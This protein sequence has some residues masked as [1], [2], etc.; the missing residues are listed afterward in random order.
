M[1]VTVSD[2]RELARTLPRASEAFVRG[3]IKFRVGR[4]VFLSFSKDGST[5]G[6]GFPKEWRTALLTARGDADHLDSLVPDEKELQR[7]GEQLVVVDHED[8]NG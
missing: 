1:P 2:V 3:R 4:I 5:M 6:F 8:A 7:V